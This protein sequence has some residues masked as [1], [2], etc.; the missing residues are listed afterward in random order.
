MLTPEQKKTVAE[1]MGWNYSTFSRQYCRYDEKGICK[2][3]NFSLNDA[4]LCMKEMQKRGEDWRKLHNFARNLYYTTE[5][6][7][8]K[9][10]Y[11]FTAWLMTMENGEAANFF[12]AMAEWIGQ[13][14][15]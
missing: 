2:L 5:R 3:I 6:E 13:E 11:N 15:K 10:D 12:S 1:W 7:N 8:L 9:I 4:A 14:E